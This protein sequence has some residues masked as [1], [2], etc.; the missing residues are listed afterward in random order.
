MSKIFTSLFLTIATLLSGLVMYTPAI[1]VSATGLPTPLLCGD[2]PGRYIDGSKADRPCKPCPVNYYCEPQPSG[3]SPE[4]PGRDGQKYSEVKAC[5][6]N[7]TTIGNTFIFQPGKTTPILADTNLNTNYPIKLGELASGITF[8]KST[9]FKCSTQTPFVDISNVDF[10]FSCV[11]SCSAN[12]I[13]T[14]TNGVNICQEPSKDCPNGQVSFNKQCY[15]C[16]SGNISIVNGTFN[17]VTTT[18]SSSVSSSSSSS[19]SSVI[20]PVI[21]CT[22]PGQVRSYG[23]CACPLPNYAVQD[24]NGNKLCTT[25]PSGNTITQVGIEQTGEIVYKCEAPA[26]NNGGGSIWPWLIGAGVVVGGLCLFNV[27]CN[28]GGS[29]TPAPTPVVTTTDTT[30]I[31][32]TTSFPTIDCVY[33]KV[34]RASDYGFNGCVCPDG[35]NDFY[36][37]CATEIN[38]PAPSQPSRKKGTDGADYFSLNDNQFYSFAN[39]DLNNYSDT[40]SFVNPSVNTF[41]DSNL[42]ASNNFSGIGY[43]NEPVFNA[44]EPSNGTYF[45]NINDQYSVNTDNIFQNND[46]VWNI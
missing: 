18:S 5:P 1:N 6:A 43:S 32:D 12:K 33:P 31:T 3:F 13:P 11:T 23:T 40:I 42:Y 21:P 36:G 34:L 17:C 44:I 25:C 10:S 7:T 20:P 15:T 9:N 16:P 30:I 19:S 2:L 8:C 27:I 46:F 28:N 29:S 38:V 26:Q 24:A 37:E 14:L 45:S 39:N 41:N 22:I 35:T 4:I